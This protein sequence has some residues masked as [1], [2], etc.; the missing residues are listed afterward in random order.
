MLPPQP[1]RSATL[2]RMAVRLQNTGQMP[3][4]LLPEDLSLQHGMTP[5]VLPAIIQDRL[6]LICVRQRQAHWQAPQGHWRWAGPT[7]LR[8][9]WRT[10]TQP[11]P[12]NGRTAGIRPSLLPTADFWSVPQALAATI[13]SDTAARTAAPAPTTVGEQARMAGESAVPLHEAAPA[14][15]NLVPTDAS[16]DVDEVTPGPGPTLDRD[17]RL[18][19]DASLIVQALQWAERTDR[20]QGITPKAFYTGLQLP[21][22]A[23]AMQLFEAL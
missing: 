21:L 22:K 5:M 15:S 11:W 19:I 9:P 16:I 18:I 6:P 17:N 8:L 20:G 1:R 10:P 7:V 4:Q 14:A 13:V 12:K 23:H 2:L 3:L